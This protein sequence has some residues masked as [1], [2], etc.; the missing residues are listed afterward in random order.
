ML[1][2]A[3]QHKEKSQSQDRDFSVCSTRDAGLLQTNQMVDRQAGF[4]SVNSVSHM[5]G[6]CRKVV[7]V[8]RTKVRPES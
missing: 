2:E 4:T 6:T 1:K 8:E 3:I 7:Y 5:L